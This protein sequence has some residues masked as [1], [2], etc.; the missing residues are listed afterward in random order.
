M[1]DDGIEDIYFTFGAGTF[2]ANFTA[3][4]H[5]FNFDD[6]NYG[7]GSEID[8]MLTRKFLNNF[9]FGLKYAFY[10]ANTNAVNV[11]RNPGQSTNITKFWTFITYQY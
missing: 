3:V 2:G 8:L 1:P 4:Y 7:Y 6:D 9:T 5:D 10:D 11:A